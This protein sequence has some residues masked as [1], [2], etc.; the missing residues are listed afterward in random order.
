MKRLLRRARRQ[1][2]RTPRVRW[3][4]HWPPPMKSG[5]NATRSSCDHLLRERELIVVRERALG[6]TVATRRA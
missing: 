4:R 5:E 3:S 1:L 6:L 2:S